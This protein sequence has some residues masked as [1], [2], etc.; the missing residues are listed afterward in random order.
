MK[1]FKVYRHTDNPMEKK[2]HDKFI[3]DFDYRMLD[4]MVL[5]ESQHVTEHEA[6][7]IVS[8]IQWLGSHV[9]QVFLRDYGFEL[10]DS[11]EL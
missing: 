1:G 4:L 11:D 8:T 5:P 9:G 2:L 7:I 10:K 3:K 6:R